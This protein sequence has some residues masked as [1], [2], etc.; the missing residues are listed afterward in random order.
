MHLT[1]VYAFDREVKSLLT[2]DHKSPVYSIMTSQRG[3]KLRVHS[4]S[5]L[6]QLNRRK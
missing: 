3:L 1:P 2:P 4:Y 6:Q 5:T